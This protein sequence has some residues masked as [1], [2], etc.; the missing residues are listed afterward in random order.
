M[1]L[2]ELKERISSNLLLSSELEVDVYFE[3]LIRR[4]I[5]LNPRISRQ[6][7]FFF[8]A[9]IELT[10]ISHNSGQPYDPLEIMNQYRERIEK[11]DKRYYRVQE[12]FKENPSDEANTLAMLYMHILRTESV[13]YATRAQFE[14]LLKN[15]GLIS[16]YDSK[17][18]FSVNGKVKLN[19]SWKTDARAIRDC[20]AHDK[21]TI[22]L[23]GEWRIEFK[24]VENGNDFYLAFTSDEFLRYLQTTGLLYKS[25]QIMIFR[26]LAGALIK[27]HFKKY[28]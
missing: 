1:H 9:H 21:Y 25:T 3:E 15:F 17:E 14:N 18:I 19:G 27:Q 10:D 28:P 23:E 5:A 13:E 4:I 12:R 11:I 20:L 8:D 24:N 16:K 6:L 22:N 7:R 26:I 2:E